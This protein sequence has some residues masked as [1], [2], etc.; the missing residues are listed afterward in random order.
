MT[1]DR[2]GKPGAGAQRLLPAGPSLPTGRN[3]LHQSLARG[4]AV[5]VEGT[6]VIRVP[7]GVREPRRQRPQRPERWGRWVLPL[8]ANGPAPTPPPAAA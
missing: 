4:Q 1:S 8:Q 6:N 3:V 7:F 2:T 5:A